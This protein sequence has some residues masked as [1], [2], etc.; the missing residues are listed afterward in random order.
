MSEVK[1]KSIVVDTLTGLMEQEYAEAGR[2][3]MID[4]VKWKDWAL[5]VVHLVNFL[6]KEGFICVLVTGYPGSGKSHAMKSLPEGT[7][8]WYNCDRKRYTWEGGKK[9]YGSIN[10]PT[11][12]QVIPKDYD[13]I[14]GHIKALK[15]KGVFED[16]PVA[17]LIGHIEDYKTKDGQVRQRFKTL[18]NLTNKLELEAKMT[19]VLYSEVIV[20]DNESRQ[21]LFR[22]IASPTDTCR[23]SE[24]MFE[25][26]YI[27]NDFS[28]VLK[29]IDN[30]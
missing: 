16:D 23:S 10:K 7:N 8:I 19:E 12:F 15:S 29:C 6:N 14:M 17:F 25:E 3:K 9:V 22:T 28:Y 11:K 26:E 4:R 21:Y 18:G 30:Y 1:V 20:D 2:K 5:D 24:G 27:P 13:E